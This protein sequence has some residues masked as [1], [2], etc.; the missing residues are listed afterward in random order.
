M[1]RVRLKW[2]VPNLEDRLAEGY[3]IQKIERDDGAGHTEISP[4]TLR[5][6][7]VADMPAYIW[8]D[9]AGDVSNNYR[10]VLFNSSTEEDYVTPVTV[11]DKEVAA[12]CTVDDIRAEGYAE[13]AISNERAAVGISLATTT[14]DKI[15]GH[16]F[17]P[18]YRVLRIDGND[19]P[20]LPLDVP[21]IA[22]MG[23][24]IDGEN[25]SLSAIK[26]ANSHLTGGDESDRHTPYIEFD[27]SSV[28]DL[29][30]MLSSSGYFFEGER[31][32]LIRGLFG[33]TEQDTEKFAG[34]TA[35][36][37]QIPLD[38]GRTPLEIKR[39]STILAIAYAYPHASG[40]AAKMSRAAR[41]IEEKNRDHSYKL[42]P[43]SEGAVS[44]GA[45][46]IDE[47]DTILER[48]MAPGYVGAIGR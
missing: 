36:G 20:L 46:G 7:L 9:P 27:T 15:C 4:A 47:V 31:N 1:S 25:V 18:R 43:V 17:A 6:P 11:T 32:V 16:W 26:V 8:E 24:E 10:V 35:E 45:T 30:L 40:K 33:C 38:F 22:L 34:E 21:V 41:V 28:N 39:A 5:P 44:S 37:S 29:G 14:I 2:T 12:Y 23:L 19:G 13:T 42:Q 3:D 48:H